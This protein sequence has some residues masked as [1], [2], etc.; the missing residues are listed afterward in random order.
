MYERALSMLGSVPH[1]KVLHAAAGMVLYGFVGLLSV[2]VAVMLV[3]VAAIAKEVLDYGSKYHTSDWLDY[4]A[5]VTV[6]TIL[7]CAQLMV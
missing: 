6:P 1:D 3:H 7:Y 5:T 2:D 4:A